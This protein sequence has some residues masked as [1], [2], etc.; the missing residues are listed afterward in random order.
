MTEAPVKYSQQGEEPIILSLLGEKVGRFLDIGAWNPTDK[1]NTRA[2]FERGWGGVMIEPSPGPLVNLI[3]E[4][5]NISRIQIVAAAAGV[6]SEGLARLH[7]SHDAV[8]TT[9][10][11]E[12]KKWK[13]QAEFNGS[14]IVPIVSVRD[15]ILHFGAFDF[16][17]IDTEGTSV[18]IF[19][20]FLRLKQ[21]PACICV[22]YNDRKREAVA[23]ADANGYEL[24]LENDTNLVFGRRAR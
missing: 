5:G 15:I 8:S 22:E 11:L 9:E 18:D 24:A 2:L 21:R 7:V 16:I 14:L 20:E 19:K 13:D 4:Y 6:S 17:S 3:S 12:F 10:E 23:H 1:S